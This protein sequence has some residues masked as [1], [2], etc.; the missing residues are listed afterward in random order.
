MLENLSNEEEFSLPGLPDQPIENLQEFQLNQE[1]EE[2][3][4]KEK[5]AEYE[6]RMKAWKDGFS[7][8]LSRYNYQK[9]E[10][11]D[12]FNMIF[13]LNDELKIKQEK[14]SLSDKEKEVIMVVDVLMRKLGE[15][16]E[17]KK[18]ITD[19]Y[20][21]KRLQ[22]EQKEKDSFTSQINKI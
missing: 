8:F 17:T 19:Y 5:K 4:I 16:L 15:I 2:G 3:A 21:K 9:K 7:D 1:A 11:Q 12:D 20:D 14:G 13:D 6:K 18:E 22:A 10:G